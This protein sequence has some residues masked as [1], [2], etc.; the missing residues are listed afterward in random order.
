MSLDKL[1]NTLVQMAEQTLD[2]NDRCDRCSAGALVR[3]ALGTLDKVLFLDFCG[4]HYARNET[5]LILSG[6][7]PVVDLRP[8]IR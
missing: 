7:S 6:W 3:V 4:H 5:E 2:A 8:G 1:H